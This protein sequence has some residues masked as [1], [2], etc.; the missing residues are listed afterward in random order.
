MGRSQRSP[1]K[2]SQYLATLVVSGTP[3]RSTAPRSMLRGL[4]VVVAPQ[5]PRNCRPLC[6]NSCTSPQCP[7]IQYPWLFQVKNVINV[8][9]SV[10]PCQNLPVMAS[11]SWNV[12]SFESCPW[13]RFCSV[14]NL[15]YM[16]SSFV[17][18]LKRI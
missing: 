15:M 12:S 5:C 14:E 11:N 2:V 4:G 6:L 7:K 18:P 8:C 16:D 10:V 17:D 1:L 13:K 9:E 3:L